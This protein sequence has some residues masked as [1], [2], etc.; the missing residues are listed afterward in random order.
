MTRFSYDPLVISGVIDATKDKFVKH[1]RTAIDEKRNVAFETNFDV[2]ETMRH[3]EMVK[4]NNFESVL[5][6]LGLKNTSIAIN[7]VKT[8]V[9]HGGHNVD[10]TSIQKRY[11][12]GLK[13]LDKNYKQFDSVFIY[14]SL[15]EFKSA[16]C[17]LMDQDRKIIKRKPSFLHHLP[18][19]K[20]EFFPKQSMGLEI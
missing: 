3:V 7:R 6:F 2:E 15:P 5:I 8:R 14:E 1:L 9:K 12:D 13:V 18:E 20:K 11:Y 19:I 10:S 4:K 16:F 17:L